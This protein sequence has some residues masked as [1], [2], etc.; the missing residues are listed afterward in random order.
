MQMKGRGAKAA[1]A[2]GIQLDVDPAR[3]RTHGILGRG[4]WAPGFPRG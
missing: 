4:F 2:L 3:V 1:P